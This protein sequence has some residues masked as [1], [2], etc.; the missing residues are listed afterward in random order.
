[1]TKFLVGAAVLVYL[2]LTVGTWLPVIVRV[3]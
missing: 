2:G 3:L 1:M